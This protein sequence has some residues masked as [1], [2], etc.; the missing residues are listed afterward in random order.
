M[1]VDVSLEQA[2]NL[3]EIQAMKR[4]NPHPNIIQLHEVI[5]WV[6]CL[7]QLNYKN[8]L[9]MIFWT[10]ELSIILFVNLLLFC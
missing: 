2:N 9:P 7:V 3:R 8:D 10:V 4:L 6:L 5:L 1:R